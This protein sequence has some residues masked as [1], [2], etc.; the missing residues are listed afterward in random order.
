MRLFKERLT[1]SYEAASQV[2]SGF[3]PNNA[4]INILLAISLVIFLITI[5]TNI[6]KV[7]KKIIRS[8]IVSEQSNA[9]TVTYKNSDGTYTKNIFTEPINYKDENGKWSKI[10]N[11]IRSNANFL[12]VDKA[13]Y[14][15]KIQKTADKPLLIKLENGQISFK[16]EG[17]NSSQAQI[18]SNKVLFK[19][20][21]KN[22]DLEIISK[23][24][25]LKENIVF[26]KAGHPMSFRETLSTSF[27]A[28]LTSKGSINYMD[29]SKVVAHSPKPYVVDAAGKIGKAS[30]AL[31]GNI[32]TV[33]MAN[34]SG[35]KYPLTLD[36]SITIMG[37]SSDGYIQYNQNAYYYGYDAFSSEDTLETGVKTGRYY[38]DDWDRTGTTFDQPARSFLKFSLASIP[39]STTITNASLKAYYYQ[40]TDFGTNNDNSNYAV[41]DH[42]EDYG[43]LDSSDWNINAYSTNVGSSNWLTGTTPMGWRTLTVTEQIQNDLA[44][45]R[46]NS[47]YRIKMANESGSKG[48]W[49]SLRSNESTLKPY[50][51]ITFSGTLTGQFTLN[52]TDDVWK[53]TSSPN[54]NGKTSVNYTGYSGDTSLIRSIFKFDLGNVPPNAYVNNATLSLYQT[55]INTVPS[56][57]TVYPLLTDFS[58]NNVLSWQVFDNYYKTPAATGMPFSTTG[59][60]INVD[61]TSH[62]QEIVD[63]SSSRQLL[64]LAKSTLEKPT[65]AAWYSY[66]GYAS[67]NNPNM[68]IRPKVNITYSFADLPVKPA[69]VTLVPQSSS[70]MQVNWQ[71]SSTNESG[72]L[73]DKSENGTS[74]HRLATVGANVTSYKEYGLKADTPY[75]YRVRSYKVNAGS[76]AATAGASRRTLSSIPE[77][78]KAII[79]SDVSGLFIT[80]SWR[81][82]GA[83]AG[84]KLFSSVDDF[85]TPIY[86]GTLTS[87]K[88]INLSPAS[89]YDYRVFSYNSENP[90]QPSKSYDFTSATTA[91]IED[92][93]DGL[94]E[95]SISII[96]SRPQITGGW[97]N[98]IPTITLL[99]SNTGNIKYSWDNPT[100]P[101][102][103]YTEPFNAPEGEHNLYYFG[104]DENGKPEDPNMWQFKVDLTR[105]SPVVGGSCETCHS[106]QATYYD[107]TPHDVKLRPEKCTRCHTDSMDLTRPKSLRDVIKDTDNNDHNI[108]GNDN[109]VCFACHTNKAG[110]YSGKAIYDQVKHGNEQ[111]SGKAA[112][113]WKDES[114]DPTMCLNC[115]DPHG[116]EGTTDYTR[117]ARNEL[118]TNCHDEPNLPPNRR[119][120][121]ATFTK[122]SETK[123]TSNYFGNYGPINARY[124]QVFMGYPFNS[125]T[126]DSID[127]SL[128]NMGLSTNVVVGGTHYV[129]A[130]TEPIL[131]PS[132]IMGD[133][134][135]SSSADLTKATQIGKV[136]PGFPNI[137][138][139]P[140]FRYNMLD[141]KNWA[142]ANR[143]KPLYITVDSI[144]NGSV[145]DNN[146]TLKLSVQTS[147]MINET[148]PSAKISTH[149]Y[150]GKDAYAN[151]IHSQ[152]ALISTDK[153]G[154]AIGTGGAQAGQC[155]NC[156]NPHGEDDGTGKPNKK[157]LMGGK[158]ENAC[159]SCHDN[160][161][162]SQNNINI[163]ERFTTADSSFPSTSSPDVSSARHG[164]SDADQQKSGVKLE[165]TSCH[166]PHLNNANNKVIDPNNPTKLFNGSTPNFCLR[167]HQN[168]SYRIQT[169]LN[170]SAWT[171][172]FDSYVIKS[173]DYSNTNHGSRSSISRTYGSIKYGTLKAPYE[174]D[175][176]PL[177]CTD[178]HDAHGSK[179]IWHLK[180]NINGTPISVT[181]KSSIGTVCSACHE[182]ISN[183]HVQ[184]CSGCHQDP[185]DYQIK[186]SMCFR[187]HAHDAVIQY[188]L[189]N[190]ASHT[191][192][193]NIDMPLF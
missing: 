50:L 100:G 52:S 13:P 181:D 54:T 58:E 110:A 73:I 78:A 43:T 37:N 86:V 32:L 106:D 74:W 162:N 174:R 170:S 95:T 108:L 18:K 82:G 138:G 66:F 20:T 17:A 193:P 102:T 185:I 48:D 111:N 6:F 9:N 38:S 173:I 99:N 85:N 75:W 3:L 24:T 4:K 189:L 61:V 192:L 157:A 117:K 150:R 120:R 30:F 26:A 169:K 92:L 70:V 118:C 34:V 134:T 8:T 14:K 60:W 154:A 19:N 146:G 7:D 53:S 141:I 104:N 67:N 145:A 101:W 164:V 160:A 161:A 151:S 136:L 167:C 91:D 63:N 124:A 171:D 188:D 179:N 12:F 172:I 47:A 155:I 149:S 65:G 126:I 190:K 107:G 41:V 49:Y 69:S 183:T 176:D 122:R 35:L 55:D 59:N 127:V 115:H 62:A 163:K 114:A 27:K 187:C 15:L 175:M 68:S 119:N 186:V 148:E 87:F 90:A 40:R 10:D 77:G 158:E 97:Y 128:L 103:T 165:C 57:F 109:T 130:S 51:S 113:R 21:F 121:G 76:S 83:Q 133:V 39:A 182:D 1:I 123:E 88:H 191:A 31:D 129:Y 132:I 33:K 84:Y 71:D 177:P 42:I 135:F 44:A 96:P 81:S 79:G 125:R 28:I 11:N 147:T 143:N 180:E 98:T 156:H 94:A 131:T 152:E 168:N 80:V 142:E 36:P 178:C 93:P 29:G 25:G 116:V 184:L 2:I 139:T 89:T 144:I 5:G 22:S 137:G 153:T 112:I 72:F 166:N 64:L 56:E 23:P 159:F 105:T 16:L 45:G 46:S 140:T